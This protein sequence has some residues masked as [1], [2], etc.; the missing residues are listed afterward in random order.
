MNEGVGTIVPRFEKL[1]LVFATVPRVLNVELL[2]IF[3][4]ILLPW[5]TSG[6]LIFAPLWILALIPR[7]DIH[8]F[9]RSLMRA[10]CLAPV[11]W[12]I[13]GV[14]ALYAMWLLHLVMFRA[15]GLVDWLGLL[16][17]VQ[18]FSSSLFNSHLFDFQEGW[19]YVVGVGVAGGMALRAKPERF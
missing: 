19:I 7:L 6:V 8:A 3:I 10:V 15:E 11:V 2:A 14:A 1:S 4:A 5:S 16:V 17:A 18:N 9:L 13:A 12:G